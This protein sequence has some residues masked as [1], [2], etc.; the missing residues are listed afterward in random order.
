MGVRLR[1]ELGTG[2]LALLIDERAQY[3]WKVAALDLACYLLDELA[4]GLELLTVVPVRKLERRLY[5]T[6][7]A[8]RRGLASDAP[9]RAGG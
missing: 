9:E 6:Y 3:G 1:D 2:L 4:N 5:R 8:R 7:D